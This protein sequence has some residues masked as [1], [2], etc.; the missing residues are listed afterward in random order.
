MMK[1]PSEPTPIGHNQPPDPIR[2]ALASYE[3]TLCEAE[4]WLDGEPVQ[5]E[6]Q[7]KQVDVLLKDVKSARKAVARVEESEAKPIYDRWKAAKARFKPTLD[8]LDR[9]VNG[10]AALMNVFKIKLAAEKAEAERKARAQAEAT[11]REAEEKARQAAAGDIAAQREAA[12]AMGDARD[13]RQAA[14]QASRDTVKGLR[15]VHRYAI[16]DHRTVHRDIAQKDRAAM[17]HFIEE[18]V[19]Q[20]H[21]RRV[22]DGV[23]TWTEKEAF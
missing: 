14:M 16:K 12:Q 3:G 7:M 5:T 18:Y 8:D 6:E 20:N 2:D 10:L 23:E 4:H 1:S 17:T 19:R 21:R 11:R 15:T 22:I 9:M 13:A